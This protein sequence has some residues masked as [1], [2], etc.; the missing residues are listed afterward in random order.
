M[1]GQTLGLF[2]AEFQLLMTLTE[3]SRY[4]ILEPTFGRLIGD[5]RVTQI[6]RILI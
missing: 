2:A 3:R 6:G 4:I 1:G 5:T